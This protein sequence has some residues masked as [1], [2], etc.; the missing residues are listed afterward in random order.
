MSNGQDHI[1]E[2]IKVSIPIF[3]LS[4]SDFFYNQAK[5]IFPAITRS[6]SQLSL[7]GISSWKINC[8]MS[9]PAFLNMCLV[10]N[11]KQFLSLMTWY[12]AVTGARSPPMPLTHTH[13]PRAAVRIES[14]AS[15]S[16]ITHTN[17]RYY[18]CLS[19]VCGRRYSWM[20]KNT[21]SGD[22]LLGFKFHLSL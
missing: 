16:C 19:W 4:K 1:I 18:N 11:C 14:P 3:N 6:H 5:P 7:G 21:A 17:H 9:L 2:L 22:R 10:T 8:L 15:A 13:Q 20:T 12:R